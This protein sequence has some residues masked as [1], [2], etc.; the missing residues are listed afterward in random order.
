[1]F[2]LDT[3]NGNVTID[4]TVTDPDAAPDAAPEIRSVVVAPPPSIG[5]YKRLRGKIAEINK[6]RDVLTKELRDNDDIGNAEFTSRLN[7]FTEDHLLEWWQFVILGDVSYRGQQVGDV[8]PPEDTDEWPL[9]LLDPKAM[10]EAL[11]HWKNVP[12]AHGGSRA[13]KTT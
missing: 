6:E 3:D 1:M 4:F 13:P 5:A 2:T 7:E 12:L 8:T 10:Q 9:Y 11:Q